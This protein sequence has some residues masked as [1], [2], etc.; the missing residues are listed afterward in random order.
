MSTQDLASQLPKE[1]FPF[2]TSTRRIRKLMPEIVKARGAQNLDVS[3]QL[4]QFEL[5]RRAGARLGSIALVVSL[6]SLLFGAGAACYARLAFV[7]SDRWE[8]K[9]FEQ[10]EQLKTL[11]TMQ[12]DV[13][14]MRAAV[15]KLATVPIPRGNSP[16]K[17]RR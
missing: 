17:P 8:K 9:Q 15:E 1:G 11:A 12:A 2:K 5:Q 4:G 3:L 16:A 6:A 14:A 7:S 10:L 13:A